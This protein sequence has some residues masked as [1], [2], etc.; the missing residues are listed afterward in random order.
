MFPISGGKVLRP[1]SPPRPTQRRSSQSTTTTT[2]SSRRTLLM[3]IAIQRSLDSV[4]KAKALILTL[5]KSD[6]I[7]EDDDGNT[8]LHYALGALLD[9]TPTKTQKDTSG[10]SSWR[11]RFSDFSF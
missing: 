10:F 4:E 7:L 3:E 2:T 5:T 6:I 8:A 11:Q 9:S 1:D